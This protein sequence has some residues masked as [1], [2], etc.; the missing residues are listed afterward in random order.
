MRMREL[1]MELV[2]REAEI[3][4]SREQIVDAIK[5]VGNELA[6]IGEEN[7]YKL[8]VTNPSYGWGGAGFLSSLKEWKDVERASIEEYVRE[9]EK[10]AARQMSFTK[11]IV[12]GES[13]IDSVYRM[14][15]ITFYFV[16]DGEK[17]AVWL[18]LSLYEDKKPIARVGRVSIL[19]DHLYHH[20]P[21]QEIPA[22][23]IKQELAKILKEPTK[24]LE[25]RS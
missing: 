25:E 3:L 5:E 24:T 20:L 14:C 13:T 2:R 22:E 4:A 23:G 10:E 21:V 18:T 17:E 1:S 19:E 12:V 9:L 6:K 8:M 7:G 11:E 16:K 15:P